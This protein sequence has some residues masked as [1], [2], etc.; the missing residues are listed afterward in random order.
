MFYEQLLRAQIPK[1]QKDTDAFTVFFALLVF[2]NV[3]AACK[4]LIKL[5]TTY[6]SML[7]LF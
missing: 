2:L 3:K 1:L 4:T 7:F 6:F 5:T